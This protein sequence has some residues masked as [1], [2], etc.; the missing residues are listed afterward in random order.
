MS[1]LRGSKQ[2]TGSVQRLLEVPTEQ[3]LCLW[4]VLKPSDS[5]VVRKSRKILNLL[6][7]KDRQ[8]ILPII[9][10][11]NIIFISFILSCCTQMFSCIKCVRH[12]I[13]K[14]ITYT[15]SAQ[16]TQPSSSKFQGDMGGQVLLVPW[17]SLSSF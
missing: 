10:K 17:I 3:Q 2:E 8:R 9:G 11:E 5:G 13:V 4:Q 7:K 6:K 16:V 12:L 1:G 14:C 15:Y